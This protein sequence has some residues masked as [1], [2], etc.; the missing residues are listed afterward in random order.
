MRDLK[1]LYEKIFNNALQSKE[2]MFD[3]LSYLGFEYDTKTSTNKYFF[4]KVPYAEQKTGSLNVFQDKQTDNWLF[5]DFLTGWS[6]NVFSLLNELGLKEKEK[7]YFLVQNYSHHL[8]LDKDEINTILEK[9]TI[10]KY[11]K[12]KVNLLNKKIKE[13]K[14][15]QNFKNKSDSKLPKILYSN[16][17]IAKIPTL[18]QIEKNVNGKMLKIYGKVIDFLKNERKITK[19]EVFVTNLIL[20][21]KKE[22]KVIGY[23]SAVIIP[24][25]MFDYNK[26]KEMNSDE[27]KDFLYKNGA[28][29]RLVEK[30]EDLKSYSKIGFENPLRKCPTFYLKRKKNL[31]VFES[32]FDYLS[33]SDLEL[34]KESDIIV[35]NGASMVLKL[36]DLLKDN[37]F[38]KEYENLIF[39]Q[40]NDEASVNMIKQFFNNDELKKRLFFKRSFCFQYKNGEE[41]KDINDLVKENKLKT[42]DEVINRLAEMKIVNPKKDYDFEYAVKK[43]MKI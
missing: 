26:L 31:V 12:V 43:K 28:E 23:N 2:L 37:N 15:Q 36:Q 7:I 8:M 27:L 42:D 18:E 38:V 10:S 33:V 14:K 3:M 22:D 6:G 13:A 39:M 4:F 41:K 1:D 9:D 16:P 17:I 35:M 25:G 40:Q 30:I 24:F 29:L 21:D 11:E 32:V 20:K 34:V 5:N 19:G